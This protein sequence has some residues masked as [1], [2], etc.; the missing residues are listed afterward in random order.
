MEDD[1]RVFSKETTEK[2]DELGIEYVWRDSCVDIL[3]ETKKCMKN[4]FTS[5]IYILNHLS[6]CKGIQD[7]WNECQKNRELKLM[8]KY[9]IKYKKIEENINKKL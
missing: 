4:D 7:L 6:V 8:D 1:F 9:F 5:G 3:V 2:L